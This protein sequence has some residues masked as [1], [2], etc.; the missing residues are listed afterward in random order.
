[1]TS[2]PEPPQP[3]GENP[4][5]PRH[6]PNLSELGKTTTESELWSLDDDLDTEGPAPDEA[7][8]PVGSAIPEPRQRKASGKSGA[9]AQGG[10]SSTAPQEQVRMNV[11]RIPSSS[12]GETSMS[13]MPSA[14]G[15]LD[16]LELWD[17]ESDEA[18]IG[19]LPPVPEVVSEPLPGGPQS[20]PGEPSA[21]VP[22]PLSREKTTVEEP[23]EF[24]VRPVPKDH[25]KPA[26]SLRPRLDL[27]GFERIGI[28]ALGAVLLAAAVYFYVFSVKRLPT[29]SLRAETTDFPIKGG[30]I[31][32]ESADTYWRIPVTEGPD[33]DTVR[34]GTQLMPEIEMRVKGRGAVRVLFRDDE[35]QFVGD[36]VTR[37]VDG[38]TTLLIPATAGF[39]DAGMHAAYRTG[40]TKP[41]TAS[42]YEGESVNSPGGGFKLLFEM[43]IS[44]NRR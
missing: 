39:E 5:P 22:E 25:G 33:A 19:D 3:E 16:D 24:S 4:L 13:S 28:I 37:P 18:A 14:Y 30:R 9:P 40:G 17:E 15:D 29:E 1:M 20:P 34:R 27:S 23:E 36:A 21:E 7:P 8:R 6:R 10:D 42:V 43:N 11:G 31:T 32:V 41:W 38:S 35:R 2:Q 26:A 12:R 44:T